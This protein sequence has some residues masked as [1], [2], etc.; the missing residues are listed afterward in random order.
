MRAVG[1]ARR[2]SDHSKSPN[3]IG[4]S[5]HRSR[6]DLELAC[7]LVPMPLSD[8]ELLVRDRGIDPI[9]LSALASI[10]IGQMSVGADPRLVE[11]A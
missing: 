1:A 7:S 2:R 5:R 4:V 3:P 11:R 8:L 10:H 6:R 9:D